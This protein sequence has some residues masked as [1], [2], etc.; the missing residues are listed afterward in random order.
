MSYRKYPDDSGWVY[1]V[2]AVIIVLLVVAILWE[3]R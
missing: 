3:L 2:V 1:L